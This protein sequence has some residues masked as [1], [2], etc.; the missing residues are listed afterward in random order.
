VTR[1]GPNALAL[2]VVVQTLRRDGFVEPKREHRFHAQRKWR[3][4]L[5]WPVH[6]IAFELE[7]MPARWTKNAK[8]RH[9]TPDGYARDIEKYN[10]AALD[11]WIVIR[12][13]SDQ[14]KSGLAAKWLSQA[15]KQRQALYSWVGSMTLG[16]A[17]VGSG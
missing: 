14:A 1:S 2:E 17:W 10:H 3:F 7:G 12:A 13:T 9:T 6:R 8:S 16:D 11:G 5:A 4:D 15:L